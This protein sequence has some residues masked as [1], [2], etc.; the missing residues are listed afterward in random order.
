MKRTGIFSLTCTALLVSLVSFFPIPDKKLVDD[1]LSS[2][3][4]FRKSQ[5]LPPLV[6]REDLN[7]IAQKHSDDMA[8]G[9]VEFGHSGFESRGSQVRKMV[10][11]TSRFA[12]NVAYGPSSG[13]DVV[14]VWKKSPGH[15]RNMLGP[16]KYIGIGIAR[17]GKG[18][19]Y[20]TQVFVD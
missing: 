18:T 2:T 20:Y 13:K 7:A 15:R 4:E 8:A 17:D 12:E 19:L 5:R 9:K 11:G 10:N 6:I 3:N 16:Y 1:V 14:S